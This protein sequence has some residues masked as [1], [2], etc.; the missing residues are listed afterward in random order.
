MK[1]S[2]Q[3]TSQFRLIGNL[4]GT[5]TV[6]KWI[7]ARLTLLGRV[8]HSPVKAFRDDL[9]GP[10]YLV[11]LVTLSILSII[12]AIMQSPVQVD[13]MRYQLESQGMQPDEIA[14]S[15]NLAGRTSNIL[16]AI[17]PLLL[18][19]RFLLIAAVLWM[20]ALPAA[21]QFG[22]QQL[23][24]IVAYSYL[25][26]L[27]RDSTSCLIL[28]LRNAEA[29]YT[30]NGLRVPLGLDL[31]LPGIPAPWTQLAVKVNLFEGW[32]LL[33]LVLGV[34]ALG[35]FAIKKALCVV[36]PSW[37]SITAIQFGLKCLGVAMQ[38]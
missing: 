23:L 12:I 17:S 29:L 27:L 13:W 36:I 9:S 19:I 3:E 18:L 32:F 6:A 5:E 28:R 38:Q 14:S 22:F 2:E 21:D 7:C 35:H 25:P 33:L 26:L 1:T 16:A 11:P 24:N 20:W 37:L 30:A 10:S 15:V 34:A 4:S 31:L 8:V